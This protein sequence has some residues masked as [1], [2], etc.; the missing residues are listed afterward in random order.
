[1]LLEGVHPSVLLNSSYTQADE[2]HRER[3]LKMMHQFASFSDGLKGL[4]SVCVCVRER[5]VHMEQSSKERKKKTH[6]ARVKIK[7]EM[8]L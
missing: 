4:Q 3:S 6:I 2:E 5:A 1:M 8:P 7:R